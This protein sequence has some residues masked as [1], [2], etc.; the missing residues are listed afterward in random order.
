MVEWKSRR[1][2]KRRSRAAERR[3]NGEGSIYPRTDGTWQLVREVLRGPNHDS[4][5][6]ESSHNVTAEGMA[7]IVSTIT[8]NP[9]EWRYMT[10]GK[11]DAGKLPP[12]ARYG[13]H[14]ASGTCSK[15]CGPPSRIG[16]DM[17]SGM[18]RGSLALH[19]TAGYRDPPNRGRAPGTRAEN[20]RPLVAR[21][22]QFSDGGTHE[23]ERDARA[24]RRIKPSAVGTSSDGPEF[25]TP[26]WGYCCRFPQLEGASLSRMAR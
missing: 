13:R 2:R 25:S 21:A 18:V 4:V 5:I 26:G 22:R 24:S 20:P 12:T 17:R 8:G 11:P 10:A 23:G 16:L 15:P 14:R 9:V 7:L 19:K 1:T 3:T 6:E